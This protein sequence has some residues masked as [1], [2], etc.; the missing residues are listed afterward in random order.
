MIE[1]RQ[2]IVTCDVCRKDIFG[3]RGF[4]CGGCQRDLCGGCAVLTTDIFDSSED[5][6][7][8][9][10]Y[11]VL[12]TLRESVEAMH[13]QYN[14]EIGQARRKFYAACKYALEPEEVVYSTL[15]I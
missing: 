3:S 1:Q 13:E 2:V 12:D 5:T 6:F 11:T 15:H 7:C 8:K 14:Q 10:C 9:S 4:V